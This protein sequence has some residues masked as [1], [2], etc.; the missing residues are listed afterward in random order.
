LSGGYTWRGSFDQATPLATPIPLTS[1]EDHPTTPYDPGDVSTVTGSVGY[2]KGRLQ[3]VATGSFSHEKETTQDGRTLSGISGLKCFEIIPPADPGDLSVCGEPIV[4]IDPPPPSA[5]HSVPVFDPGDRYFA[6]GLL[7]YDWGTSGASTLDASYSHTEKNR[8]TFL[9]SNL[10]LAQ[11]STTYT[12]T[13]SLGKEPFNSNSDFF[14]LGFQHLFAV[15][16]N[17][18]IGPVGA[19]LYR[20]SNDYPIG[21]VQYVPEQTRWSAGSVMRYTVGKLTLNARVEHVWL[22]TGAIPAPGDRL[23]SLLSSSTCVDAG[24]VGGSETCSGG[25]GLETGPVQDQIPA[26]AQPSTFSSG[27][28]GVIGLN[29]G[30]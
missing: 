8:Q 28:Q 29:I 30:F 16:D 14:R 4:P 24:G 2:Q 7:S 17:F 15:K 27:W 10:E 21:P 12:Q 19:W 20:K 3:F 6:S 1:F 18:W 22:R 23:I 9:R 25:E 26:T 5:E 13:T 11:F